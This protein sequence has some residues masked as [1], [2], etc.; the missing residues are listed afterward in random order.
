[1]LTKED[2]APLETWNIGAQFASR[3]MRGVRPNRPEHQ[4]GVSRF[5]LLQQVSTNV[6]GVTALEYALIAGLV[7]IAVVT[8]VTSLGTEVGGLFSS[9]LTGL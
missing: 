1:M 9:A 6:S 8:V 2:A 5:V 4:S 3:V 7:A